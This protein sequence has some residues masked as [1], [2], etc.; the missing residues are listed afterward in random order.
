MIKWICIDFKKT[1]GHYVYAKVDVDPSM[2]DHDIQNNV[3]VP[4]EWM[5]EYFGPSCDSWEIDDVTVLEDD[6]AARAVEGL[7]PDDV[8]MFP[9]ER[10]GNL[11]GM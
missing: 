5:Q 9:V 4:D 6:H 3:T 2:S 10:E 1:E 8:P 11:E 7:H